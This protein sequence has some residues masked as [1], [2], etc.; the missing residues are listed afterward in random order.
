MTEEKKITF[1]IATLSIIVFCAWVLKSSQQIEG[2][3]SSTVSNAIRIS[4][5]LVWF[6][7]GARILF[8]NDIELKLLAIS[9]TTGI[10][11]TIALRGFNVLFP[12]SDIGVLGAI[13]GSLAYATV[14]ML[15][16]TKFCT[17]MSVIVVSCIIIVAQITTDIVLYP[18]LGLISF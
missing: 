18:L 5:Y 3:H 10:I 2:M 9:F 12:V 11:F 8:K 6:A 1:F 13:A 14:G 15:V 17:T 16:S 4:I 7:I